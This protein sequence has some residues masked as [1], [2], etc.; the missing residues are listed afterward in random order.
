MI[1]ASRTRSSLRL[2]SVD[3]FASLSSFVSCAQFLEVGPASGVFF[4]SQR[5]LLVQI[6]AVFGPRKLVLQRLLDHHTLC[7]QLLLGFL[8]EN[9]SEYSCRWFWQTWLLL[10]WQLLICFLAFLFIGVKASNWVAHGES[11][12]ERCRLDQGV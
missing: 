8:L 5:S 4:P 12:P 6:F 7:F 11:V 10:K 9:I 2:V 1:I 3:A